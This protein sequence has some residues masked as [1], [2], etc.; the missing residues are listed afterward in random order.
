MDQ[1]RSSLRSIV[2]EEKS[3]SVSR[4]S[5]SPLKTSVVERSD[6]KILNSRKSEPGTP[7]GR[8]LPRAI[9]R[10][11]KSRRTITLDSDGPIDIIFATLEASDLLDIDRSYLTKSTRGLTSA[12]LLSSSVDRTTKSR[13]RSI[14]RPKSKKEPVESSRERDQSEEG[15]RLRN[16]TGNSFKKRLPTKTFERKLNSGV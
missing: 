9:K 11:I 14:S 15:D 12:L 8:T 3:A 5:A 4:K 13:S 6:A 10:V 16:Y 7:L 1:K 2:K